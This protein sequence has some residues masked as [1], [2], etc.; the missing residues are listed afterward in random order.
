MFL[1]A[2]QIRSD[3]C[4]PRM[5][6]H[7]LVPNFHIHLSVGDLNMNVGIRER[8]RL[9]SFISGNMCFKFSVQCLCSV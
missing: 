8:T 5:K 2:L 1:T 6:L 3:L 7:G 4:I 9:R